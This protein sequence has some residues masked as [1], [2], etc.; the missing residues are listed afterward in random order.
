LT[1]GQTVAVDANGQFTDNS[2][3]LTIVVTVGVWGVLLTR[4]HNNLA[5][6]LAALNPSWDDEKLY[7]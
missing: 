1:P 5:G 2:K 6:R 3:R 7:Q 4:N